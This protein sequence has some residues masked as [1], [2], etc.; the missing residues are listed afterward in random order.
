MG[1]PPPDADPERFILGV[2]GYDNLRTARAYNDDHVF[3]IDPAPIPVWG[4]VLFDAIF[5][6]FFFTFHWLLKYHT[7][8]E[9]GA[10]AVYGAPIVIGLM[11]CAG[12]TVLVYH[13]HSTAMRSGPWLVYDKASGVITLPREGVSFENQEIVHLQYA[14]TK[15]LFPEAY[16]RMDRFSELNLVVLRN[17]ER[18]RWPILRS[19]FTYG[20][21]DYLLKPLIANTGLKVLRVQDQVNGWK[22]SEKAYGA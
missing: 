1:R 5:I 18:K 22:I 7:H 8:G 4:I 15:R 14:T 19:I 10:L 21:F 12:F 17:G 3:R 11:T 2:G 16:A 6:G 13:A 9:A 20:A